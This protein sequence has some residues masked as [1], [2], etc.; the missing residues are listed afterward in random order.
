[1]GT[2]MADRLEKNRAAEAV[3]IDTYRSL[4]ASLGTRCV[5]FVTGAENWDGTT[6]RKILEVLGRTRSLCAFSRRWSCSGSKVAATDRVDPTS[7]DTL[8]AKEMR[9]RC[10][11]SPQR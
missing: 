5:V 3:L 2:K 11:G 7:H 10:K 9:R 6:A 8:F 1:M 4:A